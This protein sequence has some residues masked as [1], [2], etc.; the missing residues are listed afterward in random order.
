MDPNEAKVLRK[1][2]TEY[3][4]LIAVSKDMV[5]YCVLLNARCILLAKWLSEERAELNYRKKYPD[6][7]W[8]ALGDERDKLVDAAELELRAEGK[9]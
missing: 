3:R 1:L 8:T 4:D 9:L 7:P 5:T 6:R 2:L